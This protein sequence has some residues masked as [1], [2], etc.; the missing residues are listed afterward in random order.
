MTN[1]PHFFAIGKYFWAIGKETRP[2]PAANNA[3]NNS[4]H[5]AVK[6]R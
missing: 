4:F 5:R 2:V 1:P 6:F 3:D